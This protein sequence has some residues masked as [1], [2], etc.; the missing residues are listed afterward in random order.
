MHITARGIYGIGRCIFTGRMA[1]TC[2]SR[3]SALRRDIV[4]FNTHRVIYRSAACV[5]ITLACSRANAV[6]SWACLFM[7]KLSHHGLVAF[8]VAR[9]NAMQRNNRIIVRINL[10][11]VVI[12]R[13]FRAFCVY[14]VLIISAL[15]LPISKNDKAIEKWL[16]VQGGNRARV[17]VVY[18]CRHQRPVVFKLGYPSLSYEKVY[19]QRLLN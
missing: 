16:T 15:R 7:G 11:Y 3:A 17:V 9:N 8:Y 18:R 19:E 1:S 13:V 14:S 12:T 6:W 4:M 2:K 5:V 10:T